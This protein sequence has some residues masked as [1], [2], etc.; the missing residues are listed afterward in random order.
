MYGFSL[1]RLPYTQYAQGRYT[2]II[3]RLFQESLITVNMMHYNDVDL[4]VLNAESQ[5]HN[6]KINVH[7]VMI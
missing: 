6:Y 2:R 1:L 3:P 5:M 7:N 4:G